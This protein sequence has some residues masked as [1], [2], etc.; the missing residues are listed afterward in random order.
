MR[1]GVIIHS[2]DP[3]T[4]F[5]AFRLGNFALKKG[6]EVRVFLIGK[7]V[8]CDSIDNEKFKV[9]DQIREF[10]ASGGKTFSCTSCLKLR[11]KGETEACPLST[12]GDLYKIIAESDKIVSF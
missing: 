7:G 11:D 9:T 1:L 8:E 2:N 3:E 6:D 12:M 10:L 4:V 5:Q